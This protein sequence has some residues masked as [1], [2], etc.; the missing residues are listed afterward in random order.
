V[1]ARQILDRLMDGDGPTPPGRRGRRQAVVHAEAG[2]GLSLDTAQLTPA[3]L[4]TFKHAAAMADPKFYELQRHE[5]PEAKSMP[6]SP[7]N[8]P[9]SRAPRSVRFSPT[10]M[11]CSSPHPDPARPSWRA[12]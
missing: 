8:S 3:A 5:T 11:G 2:A 10:T 9:T 7:P 12:P 4:A 6:R 1:P